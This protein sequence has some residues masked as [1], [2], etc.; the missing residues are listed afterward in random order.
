MIPNA[1]VKELIYN[2]DQWMGYD[3]NETIALKVQYADNACLGGVMIW[4]ID[5]DI[6]TA[7]SGDQPDGGLN[8][9]ITTSAS[10]GNYEGTVVYS[11]DAT[12][13]SKHNNTFCSANAATYNG[14]CCSV[15]GYCGTGADYC[16]VGCQSGCDGN[17]VIAYSSSGS[18][19]GDDVYIDPS[20]WT[21]DSHNVSCNPP[22]LLI[23]PPWPLAAQSTL[24]WVPIT[25]SWDITQRLTMTTTIS[26]AAVT[27]YSVTEY[28]TTTIISVPLSTASLIDMAAVTVARGQSASSDIVA[29]VSVTPSP[30]VITYSVESID[31]ASP[32]SSSSS[33]AGGMFVGATSG[34]L[35]T[36]T[37]YPPP[38][39]FPE[40]PPVPHLHWHKGPPKPT[41]IKD[42]GKPPSNQNGCGD[43]PCC[44]GD[45]CDPDDNNGDNQNN[46]NNC[47]GSDCPDLGPNAPDSDEV[48]NQNGPN[49]L[50]C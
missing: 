22:C 47:Q 6:D 16:G 12:C 43:K 31:I 32:I 33:A 24:S 4:S 44:S 42:C 41:C 46:N 36:R 3:D 8:G 27:E 25:T 30:I 14:V 15:G 49:H 38:T 50:G 35:R 18:I 11:T 23:L 5:F 39:T 1:M 21:T 26:S 34:G 40:L 19:S 20:V 7:G 45:D 29:L 13:G 17:E 37:Y 48:S 9:S 28:P 2:H 10:L